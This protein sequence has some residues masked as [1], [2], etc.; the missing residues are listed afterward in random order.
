M[1]DAIL[2]AVQDHAESTAAELKALKDN[3]KTLSDELADMA[4]KAAGGSGFGTPVVKTVSAQISEH[5][6]L[7]ALRS[8]A[9]KSAIVPLT[10][11]IQ[12]LRKSV[13]G[14][15][16]GV[17]D[18]SFDVQPNRAPGVMNDPRRP[19]SLLDM[20]Q[21]IQVGS[22][23]FEF[24]SLDGFTD[25]ADY[26]VAEGDAKAS[27]AMPTALQTA[28]IVT[29]AAV[30]VASEQVLADAPQLQQFVNSR[31]IFGVSQKLESEIIN[32][33]GGTG[34]IDGLLNQATAFTP[35]ASI[36]TADA[37]GEAKA[38]MEVTGWTPGA[39]LMN[40]ADWQAVRSERTTDD[41]Y[42][43][44]GWDA[45]SGPNVW[46][47]PVVISAAMPAGEVIVM[48]P[49]QVALLDRQQA[50]FALGYTNNQFAQNLIS[51]RAELRAGLAVMA[52]SAVLKFSI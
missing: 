22:N 27:Q 14:D 30:L 42:V 18:N 23:S 17:G 1:T 2:K 19:L 6:Q 44:S 10:A 24:V 52:P 13:V 26:Q 49:M 29:I 48:D 31:L 34:Q 32:G 43:A 28:P 36:A 5:A 3:Q 35:T 12:S 40:P 21:R 41:V 37:I 15:A 47:V 20:M 25:A 50:T 46:G 45:P 16:G 51:A 7:E 11:S 9:T 39:V 4:Q 8:R 38:A 33:A